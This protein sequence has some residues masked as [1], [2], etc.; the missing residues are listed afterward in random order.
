[1]GSANGRR[2]YTFPESIIPER[3]KISQNVS[4]SGTKDAWHVFSND[5][6]G[7][8][9]AN[10]SPELL[11]ETSSL[12]RDTSALSSEADVLAGEAAADDINGN[13]ISGK[14]VGCEFSD[15]VVDRHLRPVFA[16]HRA[17]IRLD[18]AKSRCFKAASSFQT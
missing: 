5:E 8:N 15:I 4:S 3:G 9:L 18:F 6:A 10:K 7:S 11:P 17:A 12:T 13:S 14:S 2:W 16:Q 1:V